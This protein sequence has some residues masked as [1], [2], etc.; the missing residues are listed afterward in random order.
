MRGERPL[1][2]TAGPVSELLTSTW[3][4]WSKGAVVRNRS[5]HWSMRQLSPRKAVAADRSS[6]ARSR[7]PTKTCCLPEHSVK[8]QSK[9]RR[10]S[11]FVYVSDTHL[12]SKGMQARQPEAA[13][14]RRWS[15]QL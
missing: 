3:V 1:S 14:Y 5:D 8:A 15:Q 10:S 12:V 11:S 13:T 6:M 9:H 7:R 4:V 2:F